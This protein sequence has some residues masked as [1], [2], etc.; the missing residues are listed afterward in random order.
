MK[1]FFTGAGFDQ[2]DKID[3]VKLK[4]LLQNKDIKALKLPR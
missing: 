2:E 1:F 4:N 3:W